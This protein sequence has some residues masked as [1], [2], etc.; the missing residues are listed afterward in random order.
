NGSRPPDVASRALTP[1][2][3]RAGILRSGC[4][5]VRGLLERSRAEE[6]AAKIDR[7]F[8][9]RARYD[10]DKSFNDR[11][12]VPFEHDPRRGHAPP[13]NFIEAGGGVLAIDSPMLSFELAELYRAARLPGLSERSLRGPPVVR[14]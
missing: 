9:E 11:L 4:L 2:V 13:R 12:Y 14:G 6:L 7:S 8:T 10:S 5:L 1:E 3:R